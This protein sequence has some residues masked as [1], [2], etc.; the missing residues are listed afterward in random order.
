ML[1][2]PSRYLGSEFMS[3]NAFWLKSSDFSF[4]DYGVGSGDMYCSFL[5]KW[6]RTQSQQTDCFLREVMRCD[7]VV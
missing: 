6:T 4:Q 2:I 3:L 1:F 7:V 5:S